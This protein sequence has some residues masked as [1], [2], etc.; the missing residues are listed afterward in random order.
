MKN[1][2]RFDTTKL[3]KFGINIGGAKNSDKMFEHVKK[4][5]TRKIIKTINNDNISVEFDTLCIHGDSP[6]AAELMKD[7]HYKL[8]K[9][10]IKI[11]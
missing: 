1:T 8:K 5:I 4:I 7:L 9:I 3:Q 11:I 2:G 10:G 6:N